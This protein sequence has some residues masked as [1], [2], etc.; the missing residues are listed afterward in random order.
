[1]RIVS[2]VQPTGR[3]HLG[4]YLGAVRQFLDVQ[5]E[6]THECF[7]FIADLHALT[8]M[9]DGAALRSLTLEIAIDYLALGLDPA[10]VAIYRQSS[11]PQV[12]ELA[13]LL[14]TVTPMGIL[15]RGHA[16]KDK[17]ARG[18]AP[19][20]ALFAYP[21]LMAADILIVG[22]ERV[23]VGRDQAQHL[24]IARDLALAFNQVHGKG[25]LRLPE[26]MLPPGTDLVPGIDGRKMSKSHGN[27]IE[28]FAPEAELRRSVMSIVTDSMPLAAPKPTRGPLYS[29][30]KLLT[31]PE[32]WSRT[33]QLFT[34]GGQ[35]YDALKK[36]LLGLVLDTFRLARQRREELLRDI[37]FVESVLHSGSQRAANEADTLMERCRRVCGLA[38]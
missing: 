12:T 5:S 2:G 26:P 8:T 27:V 38:A 18:S 22:A 34:A 3:L 20:H 9:R 15:R 13:W 11:L 32:E 17:V 24:E 16:Y 4:N 6:P 33:R 1:M 7:F 28:L 25:L 30:L 37:G 29:L 10:R 36:R 23:P 14:S 21:V 19:T 35:G 31:P